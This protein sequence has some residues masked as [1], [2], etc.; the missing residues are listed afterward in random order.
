MRFRSLF[1][2][3]MLALAVRLNPAES[4]RPWV[5][6][7]S[8]G[9]LVYRTLPRGDRIADFSLCRLYGRRR[10]AAAACSRRSHRAALRRGD[11]AAIQHAIDKVSA[12]PIHGDLAGA[13]QFCLRRES[14]QCSGVLDYSPPREWFYPWK[15][16]GRQR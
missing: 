16:Y 6:L 12:K 1:P 7:D 10:C 15:R 5:S 3:L 14:F 11:T 13:A 8:S 9:K 2:L 4:Q